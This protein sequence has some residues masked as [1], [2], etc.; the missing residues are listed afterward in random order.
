MAREHGAH[1]V[2]LL[3]VCAHVNAEGDKHTPRDT[4]DEVAWVNFYVFLAIFLL[5]PPFGCWWWWRED[6]GYQPRR[7]YVQAQPVRVAE[8]KGVATE[9][10]V[11]SAFS[12]VAVQRPLLP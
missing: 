11:S 2:N 5:L 1:L 12:G 8:G 6:Y 7:V 4:S 9:S 10:Q 3:V